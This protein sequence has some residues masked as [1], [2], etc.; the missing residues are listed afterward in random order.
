MRP[1]VDVLLG[2]DGL[3]AVLFEVAERFVVEPVRGASPL[4]VLLA[5]SVLADLGDEDLF[6]VVDEFFV[7]DDFPAAA[8]DRELGADVFVGVVDVQDDFPPPD[9]AVSDAGASVF[10]PPDLFAVAEPV[11]D[12][13]AAVRA[14]V[15]EDVAPT[16]SS[17]DS[18]EGEEALRAEAVRPRRCAAARAMSPARSGR[19]ARS[20]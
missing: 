14:E 7:A 12:R 8:V 2:R 19:R 13:F 5:A 3:F 6:F 10:G 4:P 1:L 15:D 20:R 9:V 11:V 17:S 16:W 18:G